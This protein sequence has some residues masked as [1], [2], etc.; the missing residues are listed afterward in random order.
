MSY[1][2]VFSGVDVLDR[3]SFIHVLKKVRPNVVINCIGVVK[4]LSESNDPLYILP[5]PKRHTGRWLLVGAVAVL[6]II[7]IILLSRPF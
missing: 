2:K 4:Q 6:L 1:K 7:V 3:D 5:E